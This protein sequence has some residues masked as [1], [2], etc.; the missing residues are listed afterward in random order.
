MSEDHD[1]NGSYL[2]SPSLGGKNRLS[3]TPLFFWVRSTERFMKLTTSPLGFER[4]LLLLDCSFRY[5]RNG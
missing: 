1:F 4:Y 3:R 2:P 5:G